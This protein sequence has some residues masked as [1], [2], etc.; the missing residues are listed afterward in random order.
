MHGIAEWI[1]DGSR[2]Q[3]NGA[4]VPPN[5]THG[6]RDVLRECARATDAHT[7]GVA[8]KMPPTGEAIAATTANHV[9][10]AADDLSGMEIVDVRSHLSNLTHE[11]VANDQR[12]RDRLLRPFVPFVDMLVGS[13]ESG[14]E[15][16]YLD[17]VDSRFRD[18]NIFE[19][20][21]AL[22]TALNKRFHRKPLC[23][24][25]KTSPSNFYADLSSAQSKRPS[26]GSLRT[27][28]TGNTSP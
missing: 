6:Q 22:G 9:A 25:G 12:D 19:P 27:L 4:A 18:W 15:H 20:E 16:A 26:A 24:N 11:L 8:T 23:H 13:A 1:E 28:E 3:I 7:H 2:F 17:I 21:S 5:V 10:L 14:Q